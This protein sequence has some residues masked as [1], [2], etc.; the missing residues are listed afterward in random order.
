MENKIPP[1]EIANGLNSTEIKNNV[2]IP[3]VDDFIELDHVKAD[4]PIR[5]KRSKDLERPIEKSN[6]LKDNVTPITIHARDIGPVHTSPDNDTIVVSTPEGTLYITLTDP[7][8]KNASSPESADSNVQSPGY[9]SNLTSPSTE[10]TSVTMDEVQPSTS[11][12]QGAEESKALIDREAEMAQRRAG[13]RRNSISMP[14][15]Q[16][17]QMEVIKQHYLDD[18]NDISHELLEDDSA[19]P[20]DRQKSYDMATLNL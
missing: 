20:L 1:E 5:P 15:F 16:N 7:P 12:A 9:S 17:L 13:L 6:I 10:S 19:K 14:T 11:K 18:P 4:E 3:F 2:D 8:K